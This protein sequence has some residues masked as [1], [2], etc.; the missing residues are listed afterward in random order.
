M[1]SCQVCFCC[2]LTSCPAKNFAS[3]RGADQI[4]NARLIGNVTSALRISFCEQ[5]INAGRAQQ[6]LFA[7]LEGL[8][9]EA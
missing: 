1:G 9:S 7:A 5:Q 2:R 8:N 4:R 3:R 6:F